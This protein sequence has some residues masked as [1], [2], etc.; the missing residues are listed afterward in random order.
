MVATGSVAEKAPNG[1][2]GALATRVLRNSVD[3]HNG[4][5]N[6]QVALLERIPSA[7]RED[8]ILALFAFVIDHIVVRVAARAVPARAHRRVKSVLDFPTI[9]Q[10]IR[11]RL[12]ITLIDYRPLAEVIEPA[13]V[14]IGKAISVCVLRGESSEEARNR[15][16]LVNLERRMAGAVALNVAVYPAPSPAFRRDVVDEV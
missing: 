12:G 8:R 3:F 9:L 7:T 2:Q 5:V 13:L 4:P 6:R 16:R 11:R 14:T 15:L 1:K 10:T